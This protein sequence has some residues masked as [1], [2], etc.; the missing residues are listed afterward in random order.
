MAALYRREL[1]L[2]GAIDQLHFESV[3]RQRFGPI[4]GMQSGGVPQL[5]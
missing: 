3:L 5:G 2:D 4:C 1:P